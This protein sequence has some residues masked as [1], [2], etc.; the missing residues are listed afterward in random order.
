MEIDQFER[1]L[2]S[3]FEDF[4]INRV[5]VSFVQSTAKS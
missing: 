2:G 3:I 5:S 4:G 1:D